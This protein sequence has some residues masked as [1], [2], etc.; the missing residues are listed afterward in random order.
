VTNTAAGCDPAGLACGQ[1]VSATC[2]AGTAVTGCFGSPAAVCP[3][4]SVGID[5]TFINARTCTV[6]SYNASPLGL[7]G[8]VIVSVT[9]WAQCINTP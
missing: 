6:S 3:D 2:P 4:G 5:A 9:V 8:S 1:Q 7:C